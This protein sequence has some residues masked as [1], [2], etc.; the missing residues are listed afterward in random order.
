[1]SQT[2]TSRG[3]KAGETGN[4][5]T[6]TKSVVRFAS[7]EQQNGEKVAAALGGLAAELDKNVP[8]GHVTVLLGKDYKAGTGNQLT[9]DKLLTM[10]PVRQQ[11]QP[12]VGCV[13]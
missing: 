6:R 13:N 11:Q 2:L 7:G 5:S 1:V 4:A 12:D 10:D 9:G 3:F 8:K